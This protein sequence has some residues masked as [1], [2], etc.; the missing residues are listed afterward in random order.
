LA[1]SALRLTMD[2]VKVSGH[3]A[4]AD[5]DVADELSSLVAE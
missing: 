1:L 3:W 5:R 2:A 4:L